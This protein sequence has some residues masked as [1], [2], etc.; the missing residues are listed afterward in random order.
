LTVTDVRGGTASTSTTATISPAIPLQIVQTNPV[1]GATNVTT[2]TKVAVTFSKAI[3]PSSVNAASFFVGDNTT[4]VDVSGLIQVDSSNITATF[5]PS[6]PLASGHSFSATLTT[7]IKNLAGNH[8]IGS[9]NFGFITGPLSY[10]ADSLTFSVLNGTPPGAVGATSGEADSLT[11]SLLNGESPVLA[12]PTAFEVDSPT[13][14]V[15]NAAPPTGSSMWRAGLRLGNVSEPTKGSKFDI[16]ATGLAL[17]PAQA[18]SRI[19][20][21]I[22]ERVS[23][24]T[25][26]QEREQNPRIGDSNGAAKGVGTGS[27]SPFL[28]VACMTFNQSEEFV[29]RLG[30]RF[31]LPGSRVPISRVLPRQ[32]WDRIRGMRTKEEKRPPRSKAN[33]GLQ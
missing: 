25:A 10:E 14:S 11:F 18:G 33:R 21:E 5:V 26:E 3:D 19:R 20:P 1:D 17:V 9:S 13:F 8:L 16:R 4:G 6:R 7:A 15:H 12:Q 24:A 32:A 31:G 23:P 2:N 29:F 28:N 27:G 22:S 30:R